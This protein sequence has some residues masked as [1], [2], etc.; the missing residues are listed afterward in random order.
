MKQPKIPIALEGWPFILIPAILAEILALAGWGWW[1]LLFFAAT[2]FCV[3]FFRDPERYH[4]P[5]DNIVVS[6][7]DGKIIHIGLVEKSPIRGQKSLK[8]SIF[9]SVLNVHVNRFPVSGKVISRDYRPGKFLNASFD[10]ASDLNERLTLLVESDNGSEVEVAQ[11][12]G[13]IARRIVCYVEP[14]DSLEAGQRYGLIRFGS[15]VD[16]YLPP[17][18]EIQTGLGAKIIAGRDILG[19][20]K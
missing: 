1:A 18:T 20:L 6:P 4:N 14:G 8:I 9:M 5:E 15:R 2:L 17:D 11:I 3:W 13:L 19:K 7:A 10:K 12:A 16:L